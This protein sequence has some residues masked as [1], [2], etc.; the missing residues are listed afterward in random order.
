M[1]LIAWH[2]TLL[3]SSS[4]APL[5][6]VDGPIMGGEV[7]AEFAGAIASRHEVEG[8]DRFRSNRRQQ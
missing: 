3:R 6:L 8:P 5:V 4:T 1:G 2:P 7:V